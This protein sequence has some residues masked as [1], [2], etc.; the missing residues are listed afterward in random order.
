MPYD[1]KSNAGIIGIMKIPKRLLIKFLFYIS[2]IYRIKNNKIVFCNFFGKGYGCS[3][4][5]IAEEIIKQKLNYDLVWLVNS[6]K[7]FFPQEIRTVK[8]NSISSFYELATAGIWIDNQN[9]SMFVKKRKNQY[10][11]QVWHGG[12]PLKKLGI[13]NP[14]NKDK[15]NILYNSRIIN[16]RISNCVFRSNIFRNAYLYKGEILE[17]G[18]PRNDIFIN[19]RK[20][21]KK[22]VLKYYKCLPTDTLIL[23]APTWRFDREISVYSLDCSMLY[24]YYKRKG[25]ECKILIRLHYNISE[26]QYLFSYGNE[27]INATN[28]DDIQELMYAADILITDYSNIMFEFS[29]MYKPCFLFATDITKY[30]EQR[31]FYFELYKDLPF[32]IA[33]TNEELIKN[34]EN[35][36]S[37]IYAAK[38]KKYMKQVGAKESGTASRQVVDRIKKIIQEG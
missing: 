34:I 3:L 18:L 14:E 37:T 11:I 8:Y 21:I 24:K 32:S 36:D 22:D 23:Y 35:F 20:K 28:Y 33:S 4:K 29:L 9:K 7:Y 27:I 31:G 6:D 5:Y 1:K 15:K 38:I 2:R 12:Y 30:S 13:D 10:Y 17:C 16:L 19:Q 25:I 26:K